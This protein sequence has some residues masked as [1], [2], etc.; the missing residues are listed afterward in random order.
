MSLQSENGPKIPRLNKLPLIIGVSLIAIFLGAVVWGISTRG[1]FGGSPKSDVASGAPAANFAEQM[2]RGVPDAVV[3]QPRAELPVPTEQ[4]RAAAGQPANPFAAPSAVPALSKAIT[5]IEDEGIWRA[6]IEREQ[7]EAELRKQHQYR[8]A[9]VEADD[10]AV[11]SPIVVSIPNLEKVMAQ[12]GNTAAGGAGGA[13]SPSSMADLYTAQLR[14]QQQQLDPNWQSGKADF[15]EQQRGKAGYLANA[16]VPQQSRFELKRGSVIPATL[17]TGI[18]SDL[19]GRITAQVSQHIYDSASGRSILIPQGS[20]LMGRYDSKV[21]FGQ[22]RVLVVWT[23]LVMPNGSTLQLG[24]FPGMD[25]EG[26]G[27]F[28]DEVDNHYLQTFGS[29]ALIAIIGAGMDMSMPQQ[30]NNAY[31]A[32]NNQSASDSARR[33]FAET[34]GRVVERTVS[35]NMDIQPTLTIRPGY[36][37]NILVEQDI[38]FPGA[39]RS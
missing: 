23:D 13:N 21:S 38:I 22:S 17:I 37:F 27:G 26:Y 10:K 6:R 31:S 33:S 34:F 35:K 8:M 4:P 30:S 25:T 36:V 39:Y 1:I 12:P 9:R 20:K 29:A 28:K 11:D 32:S 14:L 16:V 2:K 7:K 5:G 3:E 15:L 19:P 18:N 24:G